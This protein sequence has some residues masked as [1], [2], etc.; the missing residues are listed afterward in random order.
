MNSL[1]LTASKF[2]QKTYLALY[3]TYYSK[4]KKILTY[5]LDDEIIAKSLMKEI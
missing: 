3:E 1:P 2:I 4:E 5:N